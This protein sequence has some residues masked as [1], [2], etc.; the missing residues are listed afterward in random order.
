LAAFLFGAV[1]VALLP[2]TVWL[3]ASLPPQHSTRNWDLAWSG[4]DSALAACF[5][6][7]AYAAWHGRRWLPAAAAATGALLVADAWFDIVLE[8]R[9][10][11]RSIALIE[12]FAA[13][14]P[15]AAVCFA[16]AFVT[17]RVDLRA[18]DRG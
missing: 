12:A 2:W 8:S 1:G 4:F 9:S 14:L 13:E 16:V 11:D 10:D 5:L 6:V 18:L 15:I 17:S 3:S 7:T